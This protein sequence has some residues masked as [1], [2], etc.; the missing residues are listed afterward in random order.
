MRLKWSFSA[1]Q[2]L[3]DLRAYIASDRPR[4]ATGVARRI[5]QAVEHLEQYPRMGRPGRVEGTRE[6][7]VTDTPY[8]VAYRIE[9]DVLVVLRVLHSARKWPERF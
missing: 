2:D 7:I 9:G 4:A 3:A 6:L 5:R 8:L 1:L